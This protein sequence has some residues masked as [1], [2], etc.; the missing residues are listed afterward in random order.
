MKTAKQESPSARERRGFSLPGGSEDRGPGICAV[1]IGRR[2][3][4]WWSLRWIV[5]GGKPGGD[6]LQTALP[7]HAYLVKR[8]W[9][10]KNLVGSEEAG[11]LERHYLTRFT[12]DWETFAY[13]IPEMYEVYRAAPTGI[14]GWIGTD[15]SNISKLRFSGTSLTRTLTISKSWFWCVVGHKKA[16]SFERG[17]YLTRSAVKK[18]TQAMSKAL[19]GVPIT[20]EGALSFLLVLL[21]T[22]NR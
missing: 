9:A 20:G 3:K 10:T 15:R 1:S 8:G 19:R 17:H 11:R 5:V 18:A 22:L 13:F 12:D 4:G 21:L 14:Q 16:P 2:P 7:L 6:C